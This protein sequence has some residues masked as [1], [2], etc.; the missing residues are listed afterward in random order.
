VQSLGLTGLALVDPARQLGVV[1]ALAVLAVTGMAL[2]DTCCDGMVIDVTPPGDRDRVQGTL[3][4]ARA[5]AAMV[6]SYGFGSWVDAGGAITGGA[7]RYRILLGTCAAV[8][9]IPVIQALPVAEPPRRAGTE[10]FQWSALR[11]LVRPHALL[12]LTYG[13]VYAVVAYGVEINL[14]PYYH[15]LGFREKAIGALG[16]LR[17]IGRAAGGVMLAL[18]GTRLSLRVMLGMSVLALAGSTAAQAAVEGPI[19]AAHSAFAFGVAN[20]WADALFFVLAMEAADPRMA[21]STYALFMAVTNVS[22]LGGSVFARADLA[23]GGRYRPTFIAAAIVT[24]PLLLLVTRLARTPKAKKK[25]A[26][27]E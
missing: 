13:A 14:S 19:T 16:A 15:A 4:A 5:L 20:G 27:P 22:V 2:Y 1:T 7:Q 17:Y 12:L 9:A 25:K 11:A 21:A 26:L 18:V 8:G 3:V 23:L 6:C 10:R 24:L